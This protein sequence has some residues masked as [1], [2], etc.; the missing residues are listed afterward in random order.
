MMEPKHV[1]DRF[2]VPSILV[3]LK[4]LRC[5]PTCTLYYAYAMFLTGRQGVSHDSLQHSQCTVCL[6]LHCEILQR[7]PPWPCP[8]CHS[9]DEL[10]TT[11]IVT[12]PHTWY[13]VADSARH[14]QL[15]GR[16]CLLLYGWRGHHSCSHHSAAGTASSLL[17]ISGQGMENTH[18]HL[19][20]VLP[21]VLLLC[22]WNRFEY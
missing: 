9:G 7:R 21:C 12:T 4:T 10:Y 8:G 20:K 17:P 18:I 6:C 16:Q 19:P 22:L 14:I 3:W 2:C 13:S 11:A 1:H 15:P 5:I